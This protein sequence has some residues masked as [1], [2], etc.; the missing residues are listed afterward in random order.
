MLAGFLDNFFMSEVSC[1]LAADSLDF[2]FGASTRF[3]WPKNHLARYN[4][5]FCCGTN[6]RKAGR[7]NGN[8]PF[9]VA[10][11]ATPIVLR[12]AGN[13]FFSVAIITLLFPKIVPATA[14]PH[15]SPPHPAQFPA[16]ASTDKTAAAAPPP[17]NSIPA[18]APPCRSTPPHPANPPQSVPA[19]TPR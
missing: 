3:I 18:R 8:S 11:T 7:G 12:R 10:A 16:P 1:Y 6:G 5:R 17:P 13:L 4:F 2:A 14:A 15:T 19:Q 9:V